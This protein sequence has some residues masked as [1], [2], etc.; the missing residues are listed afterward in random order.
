VI[1]MKKRKA[2]PI[3]VESYITIGGVDYNLDEMTPEQKNLVGSH[4][5]VKFLNAMFLGKAV[6]KAEK[7]PPPETVFTQ[8]ADQRAK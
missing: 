5:R 8:L 7:L 4:L 6:F 2:E 3:R 1:G